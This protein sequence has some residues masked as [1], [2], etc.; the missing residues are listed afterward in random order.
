[1]CSDVGLKC[2]IG[3]GF[4]IC[5]F[6]RDFDNCCLKQ[7]AVNYLLCRGLFYTCEGGTQCK[8]EGNVN[9]CDEWFVVRRGHY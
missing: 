3:G 7:G 4:D 6:K 5:Q 1:M 9:G 8:Y 2:V